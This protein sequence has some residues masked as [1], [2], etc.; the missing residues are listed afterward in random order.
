MSN[1]LSK[2]EKSE[3]KKLLKVGNT[4]SEV[5]YL[6][7]VSRETVRLLKTEECQQ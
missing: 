4:I 2:E 3:I 6:F 1:K 5:S 7:D